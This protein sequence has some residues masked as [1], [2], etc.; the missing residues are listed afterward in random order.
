[1]VVDADL[2]A[3]ASTE[4]AGGGDAEGLAGEIPQGHLNSAGGSHEVMRRSIGASA[5]EVATLLAERGIEH[6]NCKRIFAGEPL[7]QAQNLLLDAYTGAAISLAD[8]VVA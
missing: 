3:E 6:V 8:P 2:V 5:A 7:A 4:Q 1:M